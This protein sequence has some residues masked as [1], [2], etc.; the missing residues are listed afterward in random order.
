MK[1]V[2]LSN[3]TVHVT[4]LHLT[5]ST[6]STVFARYVLMPLVSKFAQFCIREIICVHNIARVHCIIPI[7]KSMADILTISDRVSGCHT[8]P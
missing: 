4:T 3:D 6:R 2:L 8:L 7:M 5:V 1:D